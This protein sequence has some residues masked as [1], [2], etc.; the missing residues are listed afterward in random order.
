VDFLPT[1]RTVVDTV[2]GSSERFFL[3]VEDCPGGE[4][5]VD[6]WFGDGSAITP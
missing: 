2:L 6:G 3:L 4:G 1:L 5:V